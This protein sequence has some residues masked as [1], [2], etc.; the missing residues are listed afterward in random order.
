MEQ[1]MVDGDRELQHQKKQ[2]GSPA[3]GVK[4]NDIIA[5]RS[6]CCT[7]HVCTHFV[8]ICY[9]IPDFCGGFL[10]FQRF[11]FTLTYI[12]ETKE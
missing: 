6:M 5:K 10:C 9:V 8:F 1:W 3:A 4:M 2:F 11:V 12:R 7:F